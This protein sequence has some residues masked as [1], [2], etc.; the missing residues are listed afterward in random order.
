MVEELIPNL[1]NLAVFVGAPALVLFIIYS[2]QK[3]AKTRMRAAAAQLGLVY[4][5]GRGEG[6][7]ASGAATA[8]GGAEQTDP[9]KR[10][11][12]DSAGGILSFFAPW[13]LQGDYQGRRVMIEPIMRG[14]GKSRHQYTRVTVFYRKALGLALEVGPEGFF[15]RLTRAVSLTQDIQLGDAKVDAALTV[16]GNSEAAVRSLL[17]GAPVRAALVQLVTDYAHAGA[18][19]DRVVAELRGVVSEDARL[20]AMLDAGRR[21]ADALEGES[22]FGS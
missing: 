10:L 17:S 7:P 3:N 19:D 5:D 13:R 14:H 18:L 11:N 8:A 12:G 4:S 6:A 22:R 1:F 21:V 16:A 9:L 2:M 15:S 20:R